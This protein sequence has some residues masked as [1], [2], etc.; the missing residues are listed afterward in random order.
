[1][2]IRISEDYCL[3]DILVADYANITLHHISKATPSLVKKYEMCALV[4]NT[5]NFYINNDNRA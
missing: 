2:E 4:S 3:S 1:M 5:N